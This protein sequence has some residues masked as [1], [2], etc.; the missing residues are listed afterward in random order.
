M[1]ADRLL[2]LPLALLLAGS[3]AACGGGSP[4]A[5]ES[6]KPSRTQAETPT[7]TPTPTP[8][9]EPLTPENVIA[10]LT[11]AEAALTSYDVALSVTGATPMEITGSADLAGGKQNIAMVI[12]DSELGALELRFVDGALFLKMAMLTGDLFLQLDPD[13]PSNELASAFGGLDDA[14]MESGFEGTEQAVVS[15]TP[16]GSPEV[17]DGVEVQAYE[18]V[19]DTAKFSAEAASDMLEEGMDALPPTVTFTYWV[20][21]DDVPRKTVYELNGSVTTII[22]TN[23]G[24]GSPVTAPAPE[25]ITTDMPF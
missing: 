25:Q 22:V 5:S 7:P 8:T 6:P 13:D 17:L 2:A 9:V 21:G 18:V 11:A 24:A 3:L 14:V 20:D 19:L 15:V 16:V 10:R 1:P 12:S 4:A 23:L